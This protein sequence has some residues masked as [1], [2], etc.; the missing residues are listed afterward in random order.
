[1]RL[2]LQNRCK[3]ISNFRGRVEIDETKIKIRHEKN[4]GNSF[5]AL[6]ADP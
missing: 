4:Y 6:A 3:I 2:I 5:R 1:M